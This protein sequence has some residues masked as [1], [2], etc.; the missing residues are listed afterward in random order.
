MELILSQNIAKLLKR[1]F[2][3]QNMADCIFC[4]KETRNG[5]IAG[6][7]SFCASTAFMDRHRRIIDKHDPLDPKNWHYEPKSDGNKAI[8]T[9]LPLK[10]LK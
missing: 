10:G 4:G 2:R 1:E 9:Y 3:R 8:Y 5:F 6:P 7:C